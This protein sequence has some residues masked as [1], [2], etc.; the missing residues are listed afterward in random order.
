M[1][2]QKATTLVFFLSVALHQ[3]L[4]CQ[5]SEAAFTLSID[6]ATLTFN[7]AGAHTV[8]VLITHDGTGESTFSGMSLKFGEVANA[9]LGVLPVGATINGATRG[10]VF[11]GES[12]DFDVENNRV[13]MVTIAAA[14]SDVGVSQT[15]TLFSLQFTLADLP[16]FNIGVDFVGAQRNPALSGLIEIGDEFFNPNSDTTDFQFTLTNSVAVPEPSSFL[17]LAGLSV[18]GLYYRRRKP[19][20]KA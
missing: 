18:A 3:L 8:N 13:S 17:A 1:K 12:F 19:T 6:P 11:V 15:A 14:N 4:F 9:S 10:S 2:F 20:C 7:G 16:S 5:E